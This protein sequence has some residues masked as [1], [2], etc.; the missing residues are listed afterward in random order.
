MG[1]IEIAERFKKV[2]SDEAH[3]PS[4]IAHEVVDVAKNWDAYQAEAEGLSADKWCDAN[5]GKKIVF[6]RSRAK[7]IDELGEDV[8]QSLHHDVI[9]M[10]NNLIDPALK[11]KCVKA[12]IV[13]Q[14]RRGVIAFDK[15]RAQPIVDEIRGHVKRTRRCKQCLRLHS[16]NERLRAELATLKHPN[17]AE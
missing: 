15:C 5:L 7:A 14:K 17:A 13:E 16:E 4:L 10:I 3:G 2:M 12:V 6:F 11:R 8:K 9:V 1:L